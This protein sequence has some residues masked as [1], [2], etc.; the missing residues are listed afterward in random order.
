MTCYASV[1]P[2]IGSF[3][4]YMI[5]YVPKE[6]VKAYKQD[7]KWSRYKKQIKPIK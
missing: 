1:P 6:A 4:E 7:P 3:G 5:I 2:I